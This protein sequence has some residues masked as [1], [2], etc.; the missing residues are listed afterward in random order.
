MFPSQCLHWPWLCPEG[1]WARSDLAP[2][3]DLGTSFLLEASASLQQVPSSGPRK[4]FWASLFPWCSA[5]CNLEVPLANLRALGLSVPS[6]EAV[7]A[8]R[9]GNSDVSD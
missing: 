8:V 4:L 5:V 6:P 3:C 7:Q 9:A 1:V 2:G